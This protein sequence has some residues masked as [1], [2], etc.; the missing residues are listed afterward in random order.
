MSA[1]FQL[2]REELEKLNAQFQAVIRALEKENSELRKFKPNCC[3]FH[4]KYGYSPQASSM[5][6]GDVEWGRV[7]I[8]IED[9]PY[10]VWGHE[11]KEDEA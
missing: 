10:N 3:A 7:K 9:I 1:E 11:V 8:Y 4:A 2:S 6:C 5:P